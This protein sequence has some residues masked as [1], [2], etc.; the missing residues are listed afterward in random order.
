MKVGIYMYCDY[1][2]KLTRKYCFCYTRNILYWCQ[3]TQNTKPLRLL[4]I[5]CTSYTEITDNLLLL[6]TNHQQMHKESFIIN[7]NTLL[8]VSTDDK[9]LF[10]HLLVISV[11][12]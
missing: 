10:V 5:I 3:R 7:R 1:I 12:V 8:H 4:Y 2:S 9:T 6:N 11:F